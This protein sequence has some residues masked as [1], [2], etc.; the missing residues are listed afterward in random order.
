MSIDEHSAKSAAPLA[1]GGKA[2]W[3]SKRLMGLGVGAVVA[4]AMA[5]AMWSVIQPSTSAQAELIS[6][7]HASDGI[8][9]KKD[10]VVATVNGDTVTESEIAGLLRTGVDKAIVVDRY[11]N[12]VLAAEQA[13]T[14]YAD[15]AKAAVR[16]AQREVLAT[17]YTTKRMQALRAQV[18]DAEIKSFYDHNVLDDNYKRWKVSYYL[19]TDA[20]DV[21]KTLEDLKQGD[22]K[23][24]SQLKP[25]VGNGDGYANAAQLP[26]NLGRIVSHLKKDEFSEPL[27]LRNGF[28]VLRVDEIRQDKK[29]TLED[30]KQ[31]IIERLA[32]QK[33][34]QELEQARR[35]AKVELG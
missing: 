7:A 28:L 14:L 33:F 4:G 21:R 18:T 25:L 13:Q 10:S 11:I 29:P 16:A 23:A 6:S 22:K 2:I 24:L 5:W 15:Q 1:E 26:Y 17:L 27:P 32:T 9:D 31:D 3:S 19:S 30:V 12:K 34:N 20:N 8:V 35:H